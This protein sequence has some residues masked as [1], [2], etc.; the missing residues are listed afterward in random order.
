M[1]GKIRV[2]VDDKPV[3]LFRGMTVKHALISLD[4]DLY[5]AARDGEIVVTDE[6]G[7]RV[8]LDG[9]LLDGGRLYTRQSTPTCPS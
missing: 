5:R 7:H 8:G 2:F 6:G 9:S 3:S 1:N 4:E